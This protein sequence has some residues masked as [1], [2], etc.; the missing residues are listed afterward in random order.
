[1]SRESQFSFCVVL[2]EL[3]FVFR[4][5]SYAV[6]ENYNHEVDIEI[7]RWNC[8]DNSDLQYLVQ[9]P[10]YPQMH[11]LFSGDPDATDAE[12]KYQQGGQVYKFD[13]NPGRIDWLSTAGEENVN[14]G[15]SLKTAEAVF[16][17]VDDY[18]QCLPD[19]GGNMEVRINLWNML[20]ALTPAGLSSTDIVKVVIDNFTF[21]PSGQTH[22]AVGGICTKH[23]QCELGAASCVSNVC[24]ALA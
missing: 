14:N 1:M 23:C 16:R 4:F 20:G 22:V 12:S 9:P 15:F 13:W 10:G 19:R 17:N 11:R 18:V 7:S 8:A 3:V 6:H 24:T 21:T 2:T 5:Q